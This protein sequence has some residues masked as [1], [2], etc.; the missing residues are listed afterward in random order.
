MKLLNTLFCLLFLLNGGMGQKSSKA[1]PDGDCTLASHAHQFSDLR[2]AAIE[3]LKVNKCGFSFVD[4]EEHTVG[5]DNYFQFANDFVVVDVTRDQKPRAS[6]E[7]R[8]RSKE[9]VKE[10]DRCLAMYCR[11]CK[12]AFS[13]KP[14]PGDLPPLL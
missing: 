14:M 8:E 12:V 7:M 5:P 6:L 3:V 11:A 1:A 10:N 4:L 13:L 2:F 9:S